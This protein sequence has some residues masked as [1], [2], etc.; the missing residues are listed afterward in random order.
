MIHQ[1]QQDTDHS[2]KDDIYKNNNN[3][4]KLKKIPTTV[5]STSIK[6]VEQFYKISHTNIACKL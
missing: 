5:K 2:Y 1:A 3:G 4:Y 6:I